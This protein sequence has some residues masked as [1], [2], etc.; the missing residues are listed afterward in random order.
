LVEPGHGL[1]HARP[2]PL[3]ILSRLGHFR[4]SNRWKDLVVFARI[5]LSTVESPA[6]C[7]RS[8]SFGQ[9]RSSLLSAVEIPRTPAGRQ[10]C[11]WHTLEVI[12]TTLAPETGEVSWVGMGL[13]RVLFFA[14]INTRPSESQDSLSSLEIIGLEVKSRGA[15]PAV[16]GRAGSKTDPASD[17][18]AAASRYA[19]PRNLCCFGP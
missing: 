16:S 14:E 9:S 19:A 15:S 4:R 18:H 6:G 11:P 5:Q 13:R 7:W 17:C 10:H 2:S 1:R 12:P 8:R 3:S